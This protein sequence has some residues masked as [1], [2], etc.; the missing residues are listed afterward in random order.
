MP[1]LKLLDTVKE[2]RD[3]AVAADSTAAAAFA[4]A[5]GAVP[6]RRSESG[7][8][9]DALAA[10]LAAIE[11]IRRQL[12]TELTPAEIAALTESLRLRLIEARHLR[13][14]LIEAEAA[15]ALAEAQLPPASAAATAAKV[16]LAAA[17]EL[18]AT[19]TREAAKRAGWLAD[20]AGAPATDLK[21]AAAAILADPDPA[22]PFKSAKTRAEGD[23]PTDLRARARDRAKAE[24]AAAKTFADAVGDAL[25]EL[26][27]FRQ[28]ELGPEVELADAQEKFAAAEN[29]IAAVVLRGDERLEVARGLLTGI[30]ASR[31]LTTAEKAAITA[32]TAAGKTAAALEKT[33]DGLAG[34]LRTKQAALDKKRLELRAADVDAT[35]IE[36]NAVVVALKADIAQ[37]V[38]DHKAAADAFKAAPHPVKLDDWEAAVPDHA[39]ANLLAFDR[40]AAILTELSTLDAATLASEL[41]TKEDAAALALKAADKQRRTHEFLTGTVAGRRPDA[42]VAADFLDRRELAALRGDRH[43]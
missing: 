25:A 29:A 12:A 16:H 14:A 17:R 24:G 18:F 8:A 35:N 28:G 23:V 10:K 4:A 36:S 31:P 27:K 3:A 40:A 20:L 15:L 13:Q 38:I 19:E 11:L 6:A 1:P 9:G 34:D 41:A 5:Q 32:A 37:L 30:A 7:A 26:Y 2:L 39:W 21:A 42:A 22:G 43:I 33:R